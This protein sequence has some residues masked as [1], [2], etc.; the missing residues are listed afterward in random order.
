[1]HILTS[2]Q[3]KQDPDADPHQRENWIRIRTIRDREVPK[4]TLLG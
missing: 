3:K 4:K 2:E 1:M